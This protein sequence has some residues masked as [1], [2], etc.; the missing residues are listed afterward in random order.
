MDTPA[1]LQTSLMVAMNGFS[2]ADKNARALSGM[3]PL[4]IN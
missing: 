2:A 3:I 4:M 1:S